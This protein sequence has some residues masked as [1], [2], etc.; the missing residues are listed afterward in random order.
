[1]YGQ[2]WSQQ[3]YGG[4]LAAKKNYNTHPTAKILQQQ[5]DEMKTH[6]CGYICVYT[7]VFKHL[8]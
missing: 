6:L 8:L 5:Q 2:I 1:M 7:H 4:S 3:K